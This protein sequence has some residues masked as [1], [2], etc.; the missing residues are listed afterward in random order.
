MPII[1]DDGIPE[2]AV[3]PCYGRFTISER[4]ALLN[5]FEESRLQDVFGSRGVSDTPLQECAES[6]VIPNQRLNM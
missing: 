5:A 1:V 4:I 6:P 2:Q 3:E